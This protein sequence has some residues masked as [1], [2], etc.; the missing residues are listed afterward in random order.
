MEVWMHTSVRKMELLGAA[1]LPKELRR[2]TKTRHAD[3]IAFPLLNKLAVDSKDSNAHPWRFIYRLFDLKQVLRSLGPILLNQIQ[4]PVKFWSMLEEEIKSQSMS[5]ARAAFSATWNPA[6]FL[7][8]V[9]A[10]FL[11]FIINNPRFVYQD[12]ICPTSVRG[13]G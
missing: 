5:C 11:P 4:E 1:F 10:A 8:Q 13:W 12:P 9:R 3:E 6:A 2:H 7:R